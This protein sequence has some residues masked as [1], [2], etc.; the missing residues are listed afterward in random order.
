[1]LLHDVI[2]VRVCAYTQGMT[3]TATTKPNNYEMYR[4]QGFTQSQAFR[5][6]TQDVIDWGVSQGVLESAWATPATNNAIIKTTI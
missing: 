4:Q 6:N 5:M 1:M 2:L 3:T